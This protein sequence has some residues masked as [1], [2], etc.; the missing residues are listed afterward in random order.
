MRN[1]YHKMSVLFICAISSLSI[2]AQTDPKND[3]L[4]SAK[5]C[6]EKGEY[7][8]ARSLI[9]KYAANDGDKQIATELSSKC[10]SCEEYLSK[11]NTAYIEGDLWT[12]EYYYTKLKE[13]NPKHP[14]IQQLIDKC[15]NTKNVK[16]EPAPVQ[17]PTVQTQVQSNSSTTLMK[18]KGKSSHKSLKSFLFDNEYCKNKQNKYIAWSCVGAGYPMN[19]VSG[20]EFRGGGIIGLGLYSDFGA[21]FTRI[22]VNEYHMSNDVE[23]CLKTTFHYDIGLKLFPYKGFFLD[24]GYGSV[25]P[26]SA[27]VDYE[28]YYNDNDAS[29][30]RKMVSTG[31]GFLF[32]IGYNYVGK[33]NEGLARFFFGFNTGFAHDS[34]N[35]K[36][37]PS[38]NLKI[39]CAW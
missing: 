20:I 13:L 23:H 37:Y 21:D 16:K 14:N 38:V 33:Y 12:A 15:Q 11:A 28:G 29:K 9:V 24:F 10:K 8:N 7:Q 1:F 31:H 4:T 35:E 25:A 22:T 6:I 34:V 5:T 27:E 26:T 36:K 39:G 18:E 17:Q 30:I 19:L 3:F 32:H 2:F